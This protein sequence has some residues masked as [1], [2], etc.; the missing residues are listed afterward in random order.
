[1]AHVA[2][3]RKPLPGPGQQFPK[4]LC[5]LLRCDPAASPRSCPSGKVLAGKQP[6]QVRVRRTW[7]NAS[8]RLTYQD[9][10]I[11]KKSSLARFVKNSSK[12]ALRLRGFQ[13]TFQA[14]GTH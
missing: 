3:D 1:L 5:R 11:R 13:K 10:G 12:S 9:N 6:P 8:A 7:C 4:R 14:G 2:Q